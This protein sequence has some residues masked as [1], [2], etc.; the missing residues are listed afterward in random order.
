MG[1]AIASLS[2]SIAFIVFN[3]LDW[4]TMEFP[5]SVVSVGSFT[6]NACL[7]IFAF[8]RALFVGEQK[9]AE[10]QDFRRSISA[11]ALACLV[12]LFVLR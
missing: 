5:W 10:M 11:H 9:W 2:G 6:V 7:G 4:A 3:I 8:L 12:V 1:L